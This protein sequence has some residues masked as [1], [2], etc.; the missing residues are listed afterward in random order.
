MHTRRLG[1]TDLYVSPLG[2]G[3]VKFGRNQGVKYPQAFELPDDQSIRELLALSH[4]LGI[5]LLDTAPAYGLSEARLGKLLTNRNDWVIETKVG[6]IF[7]EGQSQFDFSAQGTRLSI[8]RS[9][10]RLKTDYLDMALIHSDGQDC[11]I[12][13]EEAVLDTL[14]EL[15]RKGW[16]RAVG[17]SSKTTKGGLMAFAKDCDVVMASYHPHYTEEKAVLDYAEQHQT[18]ILIKKAFA[19]GHL[20]QFAAQAQLTQQHPIAYALDFI[21]QHQGVGSIILGTIN[22]QHLQ[23]NVAF[24]NEILSS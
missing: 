3:T 11:R 17:I 1:Q 10:K 21:F 6:E 2:L 19:S 12:L 15:K 16:L 9:L 24:A 23:Q 13:Q 18:G 14:L 20:Q 4:D 22:P 5:N 7:R 8:E